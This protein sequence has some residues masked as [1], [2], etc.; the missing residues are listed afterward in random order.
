MEKEEFKKI[1]ELLEAEETKKQIRT[2]INRHVE[3]LVAQM[4]FEESLNDIDDLG[5][6]EFLK[7]IFLTGE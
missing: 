3:Q 7:D 4:K 1:M 6:R 5:L 2:T